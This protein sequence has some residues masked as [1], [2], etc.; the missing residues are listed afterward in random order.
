MLFHYLFCVL[1]F[2]NYKISIHATNSGFAPMCHHISEIG[3]L[4]IIMDAGRCSHRLSFRNMTADRRMTLP[5]CKFGTPDN[6]FVK[7]YMT[8]PLRGFVCP[9]TSVI[10]R[11]F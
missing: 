1:M 6:L 10:I 7:S 9:P 8:A 11:Y 4:L 2:F 5:N 3:V